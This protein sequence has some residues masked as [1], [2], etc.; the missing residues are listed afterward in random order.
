M[1]ITTFQK[2]YRDE[3]KRFLVAEK[4][5]ETQESLPES[6]Q[7]GILSIVDSLSDYHEEGH[8]LSPEVLIVSDIYFLQ[9]NFPHFNKIEIGGL[10]QPFENIEAFDKILK[11][12]AL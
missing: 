10:G 1:A 6:I 4:L 3:L 11:S 2:V 8:P 7:N 9:T 5:F 12:C